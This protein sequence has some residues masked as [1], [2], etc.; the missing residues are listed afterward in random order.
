MVCNGYVVF[1][2]F[3]WLLFLMVVLIRLSR[4]S[5]VIML[6]IQCW[7]CM[8][9]FLQLL[10]LCRLLGNS[11]VYSRNQVVQYMIMNRQVLNVQW[12]ILM[13]WNFYYQ[14]VISDI[15]VYVI[16]FRCRVEQSWCCGCLMICVRFLSM[17]VID[18]LRMMFIIIWMCRNSGLVCIVVFCVGCCDVGIIGC[19]GMDFGYVQK[20]GEKRDGG[21]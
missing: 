20:S 10:Y 13:R 6:K 3:Q 17:V 8:R 21:D 19:L 16:Q 1:S 7:C 5:V 2:S 11:S 14:K 12:C 15:S 9:Q 18:R 4:V